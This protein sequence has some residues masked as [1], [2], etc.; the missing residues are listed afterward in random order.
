MVLED[1]VGGLSG[2]LRHGVHL[3]SSDGL[4]WDQHDPLKV[5]T[6]TVRWEDG[7]S[8]VFDRRE[9]PELFNANADPKG[10]GEPTHLLTGVQ[11]GDQTWC[12]VQPIAPPPEQ[13]N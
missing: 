3:V 13:A 11:L 5:Y 10:N 2:D 4:T 12:M 6:H 8:T 7:S 9:R 1:N